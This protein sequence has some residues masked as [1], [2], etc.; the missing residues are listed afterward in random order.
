MSAVI[1][2]SISWAREWEMVGGGGGIGE[3]VDGAYRLF[4]PVIG[5]ET[6]MRC[7]MSN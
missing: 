2:V 1:C 4:H 7:G 5:K 6:G 3:C